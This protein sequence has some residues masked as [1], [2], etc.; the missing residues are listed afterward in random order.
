[1]KRPVPIKILIFKIGEQFLGIDGDEIT[2]IIESPDIFP[3]KEKNIFFEG[4]ISFRGEKL[5]VLSLSK[6]LGIPSSLSKNFL[7]IVCL[8]GSYIGFLADEVK[9]IVDIFISELD[10]LPNL[11]RPKSGVNYFWAIAKF[12]EDIVFLLEINKL[13]TGEEKN[14]IEKIL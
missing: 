10:D 2:E 3:L 4:T 14:L 12:R 9:E 5:P 1:M 13:L 6:K 8:D 11:V 7:I